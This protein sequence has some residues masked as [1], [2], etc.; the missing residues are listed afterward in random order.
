[1]IAED[2]KHTV[3]KAVG[4]PYATHSR[5]SFRMFLWNLLL[6]MWFATTAVSQGEHPDPSLW[7][8]L[9]PPGKRMWIAVKCLEA[10]TWPVKQISIKSAAAEQFTAISNSFSPPTM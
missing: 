1:M 4:E 2:F 7:H 6:L 8:L 10:I 9:T 5:K 3:Y